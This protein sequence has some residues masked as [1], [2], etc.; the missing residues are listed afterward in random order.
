MDATMR[1]RRGGYTLKPTEIEGLLAK[2]TK[3]HV[4]RAFSDV[5]MELLHEAVSKRKKSVT[6]VGTK[7]LLTYRGDK[8]FFKPEY[9]FTPAGWMEIPK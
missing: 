9:G 1:M 3:G 5:G 8:F 2:S 7:Y 4:N 6:I